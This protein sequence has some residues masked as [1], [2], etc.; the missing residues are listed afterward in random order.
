VIEVRDAIVIDRSP[1]VVFREVQHL[2]L[3]LPPPSVF[4]RM[5]FPRPIA[6]QGEGLSVGAERRLV[7]HNGTVVAKVTSV[8]PGR[9]FTVALHYEDAG[10]EFF[11]RWVL[12]DD[13]TFDFEPVGAGS[14]RL[15][16]T[17]HYRRL[18]APG[19][20]F[21]PLEEYGVHEMQRY[22]LATFRAHMDPQQ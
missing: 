9:R 22:L 21:G 15:V 11:D 8:E 16:H 4:L 14:T 12:L 10:H 19:F 13:S 3:P 17:T 20:Y 5:G 18:L 7:F 1:D 2:R 6:L